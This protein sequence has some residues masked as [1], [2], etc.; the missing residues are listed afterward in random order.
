MM[1]GITV[2]LIL[3]PAWLPH[4]LKPKQSQSSQDP[5]NVH[6]GLLFMQPGMPKSQA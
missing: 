4:L 6:C 2:R 1:A 3:C 5:A